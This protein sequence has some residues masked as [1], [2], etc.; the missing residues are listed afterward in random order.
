[1]LEGNPVTTIDKDAFNGSAY[2]LTKLT[3]SKALFT[4]LPNAFLLLNNLTHLASI[5]TL[6]T[7]WDDGTMKHLGETLQTLI[8]SNVGLTSWP[9]W[10]QYLSHLGMLELS[11][12]KISVP[13]N[14]FDN[15][16]DTLFSLN[17]ENG[18]LPDVPSAVT[19]LTQLRDLVLDNNNISRV[20]GIPKSRVLSQLNMNGNT[21]WDSGQLSKTLLSV[22]DSLKYL[23]LTKNLLTYLPDLS[24]MTTLETLYLSYNAIS[25]IGTS[26]IPFSLKF[27]DLAQNNLQSVDSFM[28]NGFNLTDLKIEYNSIKELKGVDIP[29]SLTDIDISFNSITELTDDSFPSDFSIQ[30]LYLDYNPIAKVSSK[31]FASFTRLTFL[32][33]LSTKITRLPLSFTYITRTVS[34]Q[35]SENNNLICTCEEKDL[36]PWL[37]L[38][39]VSLYG[40][41]GVTTI[42]NFLNVMSD[43]C[44][45]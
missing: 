3:F 39:K 40:Q 12:A 14:G 30:T 29:A 10:I 35:L 2:T 38:Y 11:K 17:L 18:I 4:E 6:I 25:Y 8:L 42:E 37:L 33:M 27:L 26:K 19:K 43:Q 22:A 23:D 28:R 31:A 9:T 44:P 24:A 13:E 7:T 41:C 20:T 34:I 45:E 16:R 15:Q 1:M 32:S 36:R 5:D 21:I